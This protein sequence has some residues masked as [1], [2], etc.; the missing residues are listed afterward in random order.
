MFLKKITA[1]TIAA[2][3][4]IGVAAAADHFAEGCRAYEAGR[5]DSAAACFTQCLDQGLASADLYYNL[6][7]TY[8]R[9]NRLGPS[10]LNYERA[11]LLNPRNSDA[12]QNLLLACSKTT[13][14]IEA[15]PELLFVEWY[16]S[17]MQWLGARGW[18][19]LALLLC[20]C[21]AVAVCGFFLAATPEWR[22][23]CFI[24]GCIVLLLFGIALWMALASS[25][26]AA[27]RNGAIV[28][29][30]SATVKSSPDGAGVDRYILHEG[31]KVYVQDQ[32][33]DWR[34]V[35]LPDGNTGWMQQQEIET[36]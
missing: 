26:G 17:V 33:G 10:I 23:R 31:T 32:L 36:I 3:L 8:Y 7:N 1:L 24:T 25:R 9:L 30:P 15:M 21:L 20:V 18:R 12:K 27:A 29:T 16:Y 22:R 2:I 5:Y 6:G 34:K 4:G 13:D 35:R 19:I 14:N 28:M 11:L